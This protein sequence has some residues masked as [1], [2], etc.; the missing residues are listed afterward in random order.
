MIIQLTIKN[1]KSFRDEAVV[2]FAAS[3]T[4]RLSGNLLR[5]RNG[6]RFVKALALYGPNA[7]GKTT[8]LDAL[9]ALRHFVLFSSQDQK[10]TA[11]IPGF[12]SFALD[13]A[14]SNRPSRLGLTIDLDGDRYALIVAATSER[15]WHEKLTVQRT[16]AKASRKAT[17]D[18]LIQ[19]TWDS[20][21]KKYATVL[22][23]QLG[24]K[25]T[26][27]AAIEQTTPNRLMLGKLASLNSE[28]ASR[29]FA[30]F[31]DDLDF[32]DMHR[33]P[34]AEHGAL[35]DTARI[36]KEDDQFAAKII[37]FLKDADTG[38]Q[39]LQVVDEKI[40]EPVFSESDRKLEFKGRTRPGLSFQHVT[41]DGSEVIFQLQRESSGTQR[42][43]ALLTAILKP[44]QQR[45]VICVDELSASLHPDLVR[46][47]LSIV[48]SRQYNPLGNQLLFTTHDTHLINPSELLR[49][50]QVTICEK[51]RF[52][53][54][55]V[56]R[57]DSFQDDARSD[58][59]LQ[60]Q[61]LQG[62][63]GG[64]PNFGPTLE[65]VPI[66]DAPLEVTA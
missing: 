17:S 55:I 9:Y 59:N 10:P 41:E 56:T 18:I 24:P 16:S 27:D 54:S 29:V 21:R 33:N 13:K 65:D 48:H 58:A 40:V 52:G 51:D 31:D 4:A 12:E 6:D 2:S 26:R 61:Y 45:R 37:R 19:R 62:R 49:R 60:K 36:M 38:V 63:F 35:A 66:D 14:W 8:V 30:W 22:G 34:F 11:K 25:A 20:D 3:K 46:R 7:S 53:R 57:L 64:M 15:V 39:R 47:L 50:D 28:I 1:F 44:S 43:V 5:H 42:F 23:E 32:Y